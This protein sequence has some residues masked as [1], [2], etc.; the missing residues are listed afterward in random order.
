MN[1]I[2]F[3]TAISCWGIA[4]SCLVWWVLSVASKITYVT[5]ADGRQEARSLPLLFRLLL[6][7]SHN[8]DKMLKK[9]SFQGAIHEASWQLTAA[10]FEGLLSAREFIAIKFLLPMC[11]AIFFSPLLLIMG[12][13]GVMPWVMITLIFWIWPLRWLRNARAQRAKSILR[14]LPFVLDLLTLSVE[15]GLD[16]M[17]AVQRNCERRKM[18]PLNEE[19]LRM[20]REIQI[21]TTRRIALQ[22]LSER[23][24]IPQVRTLCTA[25]IQADELGVSIGTILRIQAEQL[26]Q[27]R[28]E[29][30]EKQANEA[31]TK[32]LF[33]LLL[34]IFP[35][36]LVVLVGPVLMAAM[37]DFLAQ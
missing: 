22:N 7:L 15:A 24:R 35:A 37:K 14:A 16:F 33:P 27:E 11:A 21:G 12:R 13:D 31:P 23:V 10:G 1:N 32:I 36:T 18:D 29:R 2:L 19:L 8:F 25:L 30:A 20:Q 34:F 5:L 9:P 17:G 4:I 28:F 26:R 6:P 3:Y